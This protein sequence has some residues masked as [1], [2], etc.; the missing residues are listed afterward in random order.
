MKEQLI[1]KIKHSNVLGWLYVHLMK[2]F[3]YCLNII[4]KA[5]PKRIIFSSFSGRQVSDSPKA[6]YDAI[7]ADDRFNNYQLKW[8]VRDTSKYEFIPENEKV[9]INKLNFFIELFKSK[10]WV[11]NASIERLIPINTKKHIYINS[12]HGVPLKHLGPDETNL[13][14]SVKNWYHNVQFD[15]LTASGSYDLKIFKHIFPN[16]QNIQ[17]VGLPRN[18][19]LVSDM[20]NEFEIKQELMKELQLDQNKPILLYAPTFREY[21][22]EMNNSKNEFF[23]P[24]F[25]DDISNQYNVLIRGHYFSENNI[26]KNKVIDVSNYPNLNHLMIASDL[27]ITDYSS[28]MFDYMLLKKNIALYMYDFEDY[29]QYRGMYFNPKNL[30]I[31]TCTNITDLL[32]VVKKKINTDYTKL[33]QYNSLQEPIQM[34]KQ[35]ILEEKE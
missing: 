22:L 7:K 2:V 31:T 20:S 3:Y 33:E 13:E 28:I 6:I 5:D 14:F 4:I 30:G 27:L 23:N 26:I 8:A 21:A 17:A 10:Y 32:Q 15:L 19:V 18:E 35:Y 9:N 1:S 16:T 24:S 12:W 25:L 11:S 34:I 29:Y